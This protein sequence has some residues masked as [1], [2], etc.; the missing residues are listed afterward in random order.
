MSNVISIR[1]TPGAA[2]HHL[3]L[4]FWG[5]GEQL[6]LISRL[7]QPA[8]P[9]QV[10]CVPHYLRFKP[11]PFCSESSVRVSLENPIR[12]SPAR[13]LLAAGGMCIYLLL[14]DT[15]GCQELTGGSCVMGIFSTVPTSILRCQIQR[16]TPCLM[17]QLEGPSIHLPEQSRSY[18]QPHLDQLVLAVPFSF[19]SL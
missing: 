8:F 9:S 19:R 3:V 1:A 12:L 11:L 15:Y 4:R 2:V 10:L 14:G 16:L 13:A 18:L 7:S 6:P 17:R 5:C